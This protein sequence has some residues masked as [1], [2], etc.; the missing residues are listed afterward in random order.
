MYTF[1]LISAISGDP[2]SKEIDA[3]NSSKVQVEVITIYNKNEVHVMD[4]LFSSILI[5]IL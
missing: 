4:H 2:S 3:L 1:K 5:A